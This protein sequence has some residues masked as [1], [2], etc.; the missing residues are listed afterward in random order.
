MHQRP[1][2]VLAKERGPDAISINH[3]QLVHTPQQHRPAQLQ[4]RYNLFE[5]LRFLELLICMA[6]YYLY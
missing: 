4:E 1:F 6:E 5:G 2:Y 3:R